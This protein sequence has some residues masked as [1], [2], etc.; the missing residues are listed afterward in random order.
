M[1]KFPDPGNTID[2]V[3]NDNHFLGMLMVMTAVLVD[4]A[5]YMAVPGD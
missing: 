5:Q 2:D 3:R 1:S 4:I